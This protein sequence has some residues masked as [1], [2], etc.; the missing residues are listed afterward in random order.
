MFRK[1]QGEL[2]P[3]DEMDNARDEER[4]NNARARLVCGCVAKNPVSVYDVEDLWWSNSAGTN[5]VR[6]R[7]P[8][9]EA[10]YD[11]QDKRITMPRFIDKQTAG[12][13]IA[14]NAEIDEM[15]GHGEII[16]KTKAPLR[17]ANREANSLEKLQEKGEVCHENEK[18]EEF[19]ASVKNKLSKYAHL[20]WPRGPPTTKRWI[21]W[22]ELHNKKVQAAKDAAMAAYLEQR[23]MQQ[24]GF[25][26]KRIYDDQ[27]DWNS[28]SSSFD[29]EEELQNP[30]YGRAEG[31][32]RPESNPA[33][34]RHPSLTKNPMWDMMGKS[35]DPRKD[36]P[37]M[38]MDDHI[39]H[40]QYLKK[41]RRFGIDHSLIPERDQLRWDGRPAPL[42]YDMNRVLETLDL[43]SYVDTETE[44]QSTVDIWHRNTKKSS[45]QR[46]W[47]SQMQGSQVQG[48]GDS[49][50]QSAGSFAE[51]QDHLQAQEE[52]KV[53]LYSR[54]FKITAQLGDEF[55]GKDLEIPFQ[56]DFYKKDFHDE[57]FE[58]PNE[59]EH[60]KLVDEDDRKFW[61]EIIR[62]LHHH[63]ESFLSWITCCSPKMDVRPKVLL[64]TQ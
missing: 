49:I 16:L 52:N 14:I 12:Q 35:R 51:Y 47:N 43:G 58:D 54:H 9:Y 31:D 62:P 21:I 32:N 63:T 61:D 40:Y 6:R 18:Q 45:G 17:V 50:L 29:E 44:S 37:T 27:D 23:A 42:P 57:E 56:V 60:H 2:L 28:Q 30:H 11:F 53:P 48:S 41:E 3:E 36:I 55:G 25:Q 38:R 1:D 59:E 22:R 26:K 10:V 15:R 33:I 13:M 34:N 4:R 8:E 20:A 7:P 24:A 5:S 39:I 64:Q 46:Q 19:E